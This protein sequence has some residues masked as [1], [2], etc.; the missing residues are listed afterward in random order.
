LNYSLPIAIFCIALL[1]CKQ[2]DPVPKETYLVWSDEFDGQSLDLDKW[3]V[4]TGDGANYGLWLWGNNEE[5][6]YQSSNIIV[7]NGRLKIKAVK[8][9]VGSFEYTSARIRTANKGDFKYG[10]I[11][12]SIRMDQS[13]GLW[14][15]F[16]ML[17]TDA[18]DPWPISGEIDIMEY[19][20]NMP[21]QLLN[22]VHFA[23]QFGNHSSLGASSYFVNDN[24]FHVYA[25]DWDENLI[26]WTLDGEE[27][28]VLERGNAAIAQTWPFDA[29]FHLV[30]N[31]AV[32][33]N[34]GG[35]V[36]DGALATPRYMEVEY[37]RIYQE[38]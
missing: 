2:S 18:S 17:P 27:T 28:F 15:A 35:E 19:V 25:I 9:N 4:Q 12:A 22:T 6:W 21:D 13:A 24:N 14:H 7:Q 11:E 32:G 26:T 37:V 1:G 16:W 31:T 33:G 30:L 3:D 20:G 36:D 10:R 38:E 5:Q 23:D 34:L 8:E 29:E